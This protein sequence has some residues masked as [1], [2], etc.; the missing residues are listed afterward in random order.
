MKRPSLRTGIVCALLAVLLLSPFVEP[1]VAD[2]STSLDMSNDEADA[3][4]DGSIALS[5][6]LE[7]TTSETVDAVSNVTNSTVGAITDTTAGVVNETTDAVDDT[8]DVGENTTDTVDDSSSA[9]ATNETATVPSTDEKPTDVVVNDSDLSTVTDGAG[10]LLNESDGDGLV[11]L[12]V[13]DALGLGELI[14][15]Q[16]LSSPTLKPEPP[17]LPGDERSSDTSGGDGS[18]NDSSNG[19]ENDPTA[20]APERTPSSEPTVETNRTAEPTSE[21]T[22]PTETPVATE[23]PS[24]ENEST[25]AVPLSFGWLDTSVLVDNAPSMGLALLA[26]AAKPIYGAVAGAFAI[27]ADLMWRMAAVLR[28]S[29][30]DGSDPLEHETRDELYDLVVSEPG[31]AMSA[32]ADSLETPLSTTRHHIR[33]LETERIITTKKQRGNRRLYPLGADDELMLTTLDQPAMDVLHA[34][35][36]RETATVGDVVEDTEKSYSTVSYHLS[37]LAEEGWIEQEKK[38]RQT[39]SQVTRTAKSKLKAS[40]TVSERATAD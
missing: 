22:E 38:G 37:R 20:T 14:D 35:E 18:P 5:S 26:I 29:R 3:E 10:W 4:L 13:L 25:A 30:R 24:T 19:S 33:V 11:D 1:A 39:V 6:S 9:D 27:V 31:I 28:Y 16:T 36:R 12:L 23:S 2:T 7:N 40:T 32:V 17:S 15:A 21:V 8:T 34:V